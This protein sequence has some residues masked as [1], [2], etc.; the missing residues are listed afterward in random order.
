MARKNSSF[1]GCPEG[2]GPA[3]KADDHSL[4]RD[5]RFRYRSFHRLTRPASTVHADFNAVVVDTGQ[6][7]TGYPMDGLGYLLMPRVQIGLAVFDLRSRSPLAWRITPDDSRQVS[8]G[9]CGLIARRLGRDRSR[10]G[11]W[12]GRQH[13][14]RHAA[15]SVGRGGCRRACG[16]GVPIDEH[17]HPHKDCHG[18]NGQAHDSKDAPVRA[19]AHATA[20]ESTPLLHSRQRLHVQTPR[21]TG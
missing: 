20:P 1:G 10:Y 14:R 3:A 15:R 9:A 21:W 5:V 18:Q 13:T 12:N 11:G 16:I 8:R 2:E 6:R 19:P 4:P 7:D 17:D